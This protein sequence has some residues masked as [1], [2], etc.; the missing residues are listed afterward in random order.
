[1]GLTFMERVQRMMDTEHPLPKEEW[2]TVR[3]ALSTTDASILIPQVITGVMREAAEPV[4][5]GTKFLQ[6]VRLIG[7]RSIIIPAVGE[8]RA[9]DIPEGAPY[10]EES[11]DFELLE[12]SG[13]VRV[14]KTGLIVRVTDEMVN[15]SQ[16]D[17]IGI[18]LRKAGRAMA[19]LKEEKAFNAFSRHG[20]LVFD[21]NLRQQYPNAG[22][23]GRDFKGKFNNTMS[24]EDFIDMFVAVMANGYV[25]TD[26]IMHPLC[27]MIFAKNQVIG[28]LAMGAFGA[29]PSQMALKPEAVQGR[30]PFPITIN[31]SPFVP[32]DRFNRVFDMYVVDRNEV[33]ILLVKDDLGTEEWTDPERDIHAIKVRERYGIGVLNE[34]KAIA[35]ARNIRFAVSYDIPERYVTLDANNIDAPSDEI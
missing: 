10:P 11:I 24:V 33:G 29:E 4:Y 9:H 34:G 25:P 15:D 20:H 17:V 2:V 13:E 6:P 18:L 22:T 30:L 21:N 28:S 1:M 26:V 7:G 35:V 16:W 19:R 27:W 23:T 14:G 3:E 5:I 8:M 12:G 32:F 31:F